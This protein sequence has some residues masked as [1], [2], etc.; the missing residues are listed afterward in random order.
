M[1]RLL[2][3]LLVACGQPAAKIDVQLTAT[4]DDPAVVREVWST[5]FRSAR[6]TGELPIIS[7]N[8]RIVD[9]A[10]SLGTTL[11]ADS[12]EP[13]MIERARE[14]VIALA[15]KQHVLAIHRTV[16][17]EALATTLRDTFDV[18]VHTPLERPG[19]LVVAAPLARIAEALPPSAIIEPT[20]SS[21]HTTI[22]LTATATLDGTIIASATADL[23]TPNAVELKFTETG[24]RGMEALTDAARGEHLVFVIDGRFALAPRV[25]VRVS[26]SLR[27][28]LPASFDA[29]QTRL[30]A[31]ALA[32]SNLPSPPRVLDVSATCG[33]R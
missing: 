32:A 15:T 6:D 5:R 3:L 11:R 8:A 28:D 14:A 18:D 10:L 23:G 16:D 20:S 24:T 9:G 7:A 17:A 26:H 33:A 30:L 29:T 4:A 27:L 12:C 13:V 19:Q 1:K 2:P 31:D 25:M 22:W 21:T